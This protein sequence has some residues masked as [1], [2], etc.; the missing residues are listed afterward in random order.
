MPIWAGDFMSLTATWTGEEAA[1]YLLLLTYEWG[2]GPLPS[3]PKKLAQIARYPQKAFDRLWVRVRTRFTENPDGLIDPD[4]EER[5]AESLALRDKHREGGR[6]G[7]AIRWR[8]SKADGSLSESLSES[9]SASLAEPL[10]VS[11]PSQANPIQFTS[12]ETL[13]YR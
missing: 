8:S 13:I 9:P 2:S 7:N 3:D 12:K 11:P 5:R 6:K 4:L 1:L 10:S